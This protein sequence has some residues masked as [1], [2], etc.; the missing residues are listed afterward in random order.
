VFGRIPD[1]GAAI[2]KR[3]ACDKTFP[4]LNGTRHALRDKFCAQ[5]WWGGLRG[6]GVNHG[7]GLRQQWAAG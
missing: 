2:A 1:I 6:V 5:R 3:N 4:N 7:F